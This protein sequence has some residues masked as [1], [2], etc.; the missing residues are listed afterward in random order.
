MAK[1]L[2][3]F[4]SEG[5]FSVSEETIID[6]NRNL[7]DVNT[8]KLSNSENATGYKYEYISFADVSTTGAQILNPEFQV[9]E[10]TI[11]FANT[12]LMGTTNYDALGNGPEDFEYALELKV[13]ILSDGS[14]N[15][16]L[17]ATQKNV[18]K[19]NIPSVDSWLVDPHINNTQNTFSYQVDFLTTSGLT[20]TIKWVG[21]TDLSLFNR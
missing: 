18:I 8:I 7:V 15:L 9:P 11:I 5:G 4:Q 17:S 21:K 20:P 12:F 13:V 10:N 16:T 14:N 2:K 6:P 1:I 3:P 19:E